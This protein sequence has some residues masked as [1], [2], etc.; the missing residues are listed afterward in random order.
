MLGWRQSSR[1]GVRLGRYTL[2]SVVAVVTSEVAFVLCYGSGLVGT[3]AASAVAFI[4]GALPNY[5]LNRSWAFGRRG[6]V[7][8]GREVVL[9]II[10]SLV[11]FGAA[12]VATG[13][14][15]HHI[16]NIA[17]SRDVRT[18][19]VAGAYLATTGVLFV[20]KFVVFQLFIFADDPS[21]KAVAEDSEG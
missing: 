20:A 4:A 8:V 2:G 18:A 3:T 10:V 21:D 5:V 12:A 13:W 11:S 6:K 7:R 1:L 9:Y 15:S 19:L 14:T 17:H 16:R